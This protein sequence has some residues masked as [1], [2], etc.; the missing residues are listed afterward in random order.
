MEKSSEFNLKMEIAFSFLKSFKLKSKH[1]GSFEMKRT[2]Q[3]I[4]RTIQKFLE[5]IQYNFNF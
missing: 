1:Y 2:C 5:V 3:L 4:M